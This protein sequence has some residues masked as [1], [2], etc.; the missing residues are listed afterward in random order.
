MYIYRCE[1]TLEGVFTAIYRVYEEHRNRDEVRLA[2]EDEAWLFSTEI[3]VETDSVRA[4]KVIRTLRK[5]FGD[6]DYEYLCL[7][8]ATPDMEKAQAVYRTVAAGLDGGYGFGQ[9]FDN[10]TD[11][12]IHKTFRLATNAGRESGH[13]REFVRFAE[14]EN[15]VLYSKIAPRSNILTFLMPHF[16]DRFPEEDFILHDVGRDWFG[17]HPAGARWFLLRGEALSGEYSEGAYSA[18]ESKYQMLFKHLCKSIAI[19]ERRNSKLQT[20][21]LP[22]RFRE[23]MTE[24]Q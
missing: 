22:L 9:L 23:Y 8:L 5:R 4:E 3:S 1:D 20:G 12:Y 11:E 19:D 13:L 18:E 6:K 17:V 16:A 14:L 10:L 7:A 21:M 2:L 24:F 15:G